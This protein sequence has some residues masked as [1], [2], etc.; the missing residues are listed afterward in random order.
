MRDHCSTLPDCGSPLLNPPGHLRSPLTRRNHEDLARLESAFT[1]DFSGPTRPECR[2]TTTRV[3]PSWH[4]ALLNTFHVGGAIHGGLDEATLHQ[5]AA[6]LDDSAVAQANVI[7]ALHH[8]PVE[9]AGKL[10]PWGNNCLVDGADKLVALLEARPQCKVAVHGHLHAD[11]VKH[12]GQCTIYCTPSTCTQ[13]V[14][15]SDTWQKDTASLPGF[16]VLRL[17]ADGSVDTALH[18][19]DCSHACVP[20]AEP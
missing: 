2:L 16:R 7:L 11:V 6:F 10:P 20:S 17:H 5:L 12:V 19:V 13:T 15:Q 18:R 1:P 14:V 8:P 9:P 3:S 4:L